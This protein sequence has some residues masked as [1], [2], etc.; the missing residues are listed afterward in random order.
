MAHNNNI[1]WT[2][3]VG[4][5]GPKFAHAW[6][7]LRGCQAY[8]F[9][10]ALFSAN[11]IL[12]HMDILM[13]P[14]PPPL[15]LFKLSFLPSFSWTEG[16]GL[17][18]LFICYADWSSPGELLHHNLPPSLPPSSYPHLLP[19]FSRIDEIGNHYRRLAAAAERL[20]TF[21]VWEEDGGEGGREVLV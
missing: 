5:N 16:Q 15:L 19:G 14:P 7:R 20:L 13:K 17:N 21:R 6:S 3:L 2:V 11:W 1:I 4:Q 10:L 12:L 8:L 9:T 18:Y